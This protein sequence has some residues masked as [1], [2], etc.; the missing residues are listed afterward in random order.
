MKTKMSAFDPKNEWRSRAWDMCLVFMGAFCLLGLGM[1]MMQVSIKQSV[2]ASSEKSDI[3]TVSQKVALSSGYHVVAY[4]GEIVTFTHVIT[5]EGL[6]SDT[7]GIEATSEHNWPVL[8]SQ[9]ET[10][11]TT[12]TS[13]TIWLPLPLGVGEAMTFN[14]QIS[15]PAEML[16]GTINI[17]AGITDTIVVTATSSVS[18]TIY[19]V[20]TDTL[21]INAH[22]SKS[23]FLPLITCQRPPIVKLG[24]DFAAPLPS[25]ELLEYDVPLAQAMGVGWV[26]VYLP[27]EDIEPAPGEY[28]W[29]AY[30]VTVN[31]LVELGLHPLALVYGPPAWAAVENCGPISDTV[32]FQVFLD[33]LLTRYGVYIDAWEFVNEPD[34]MYPHPW[35]A[36]AGCWG[37]R[38]ELYAEQLQIFHER[39]KEAGASDLVVFGGL[40]YDNWI[41]GN[42]AR[43]FFTQTLQH[44]AGQYF[45]VAN[46]H[47]YPINFVEFPTMAHKIG[48]IREIMEHNGVYGKRIWVTETGMWINLSGSIERQRGFIAKEFARGFDLH[49]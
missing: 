46:L 33:N 26:R 14:V 48:E 15:V 29:E 21:T 22:L 28:H 12:Q 10:T 44:G 17:I 8:L 23:V 3:S 38:P 7:F 5:N 20:V 45:D 6:L 43:D 19:G 24:A 11:E 41:N 25:S 9:P 30:D 16:S 31:R 1:L 47:Y 40:A 49:H 36:T 4:P 2:S 18:P 27:W 34:G 39:I 13:G 32:A 35:G 42:V 37:L